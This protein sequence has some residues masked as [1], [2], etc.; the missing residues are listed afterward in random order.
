MAKE[1]QRNFTKQFN[2]ETAESGLNTKNKKE[3]LKCQ[4]IV[5]G[6]ML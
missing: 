3:E 1:Q 6:I 5:S 2:N 4:D